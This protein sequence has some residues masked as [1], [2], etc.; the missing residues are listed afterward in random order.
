MAEWLGRSLMTLG[1]PGSNTACARD[2]SKNK[3]MEIGARRSSKLGK[4][5]TPLLVQAVHS[6]GH[7]LKD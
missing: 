3:K 2:F 1:V 5:V 7:R 4:V 6:H